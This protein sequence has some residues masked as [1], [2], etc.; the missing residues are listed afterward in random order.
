M[1]GRLNPSR[2]ARKETRRSVVK[3]SAGKK[4]ARC[5]KPP[6]SGSRDRHGLI[7]PDLLELT[8]SIA[9]MV[10]QSGSIEVLAFLGFNRHQEIARLENAVLAVEMAFEEFFEFF[11]LGFNLPAFLDQAE[12]RL[13]VQNRCFPP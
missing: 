3:R 12:Q 11:L 1:L 10:F 7:G 5:S 9:E 13:R 2:L 6:A 4:V 8:E